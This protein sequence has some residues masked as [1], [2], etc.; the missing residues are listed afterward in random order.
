M[1]NIS[2]PPPIHHP[3]QLVECKSEGF[4]RSNSN[5]SQQNIK[6]HPLEV[7]E[8][9]NQQARPEGSLSYDPEPT[10]GLEE[11]GEVDGKGRRPILLGGPEETCLLAS[12]FLV[13]CELHI[14]WLKEAMDH[15]PIVLMSIILFPVTAGWNDGSFGPL[16]LT[17]QNHYNVSLRM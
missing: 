8:K 1:T 7:E 3:I 13:L 17:I 12:L 5:F 6:E 2:S 4:P 16:L 9:I 14:I 11:E 15:I 10:S